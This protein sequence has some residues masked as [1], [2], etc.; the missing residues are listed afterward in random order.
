MRRLKATN[1]LLA[2]RML[3]REWHAGELRI[4]SAALVVAVGSITAVG[5]FTD[6]VEQAMVM[7]AAELLAADTLMHSSEPISESYLDSARSLGLESARTLS[8]RSVLLIA[9]AFQLTEVKAVGPGYPL[10]GKLRIADTPFELAAPETDAIPAI[11]SVWLDERL[12][13]V[14]DVVV[15]DTLELGLAKFTIEAVLVYEP[16]RGGDLFSIAPRLMMHLDDVAATDL[17]QPGSRVTHTVLFAGDSGAITAYRDQHEP[18]LNDREHFHDVKDARPEMR[19]AL[20]RAEQFLGLAALVSVM[21][22]GAAIAVSS[23][24]YASRQLDAAAIMRCLGASQAVIS[25]LYAIQVFAL[26]LVASLLGCLAGYLAQLVLVILFKDLLVGSLPSPTFMPIG[27]GLMTGI[28]TLAGFAL[29]PIL[30][31]K[32]VPPSRVLRRELG[33]IPVISWSAMLAPLSALFVLILWQAQDLQ[34]A[35]YVLAGALVSVALLALAA[36]VLVKLLRGL[37]KNVGVALRFGLSNITRRAPSSVLQVTAFGLGIMMLLLLTIV[38]SDVLDEWQRNLPADAP[39]FFLINIQPS[40][41]DALRAWMEERGLGQIALYPMVRGRLEAINEREVSSEDYDEDR[42][43][44]LARREFNLSWTSQLPA[45][46]RVVSGQWW[47][48][49]ED[50]PVFSVEEGLAETLGIALGDALTFDIAGQIVQAQVTNLRF[51]EWDSFNVNF[52]VVSPP[53]L[54]KDHPATFISSFHL[55]RGRRPLLV[56]LVREF[57]SV[58]VLDVDA[59]LTKVRQIMERAVLGVEYV[60]A[61]TLVAG[62]I[63]LIAAV[64]STMDERRFETAIIRTL[65]G[66]KCALL[67]GLL[68]E[69]V[70]LGCLAGG[71]AALFATL[72]GAVLAEQ[73]FEL[74]YQPDA[75]LMIVGVAAGGIGIG[76]AGVLRAR[77]ALQHPPIQVLR[78]I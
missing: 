20:Q 22:S 75:S 42:A 63:V 34:L 70:T 10:R 52:F 64:E 19:I 8:F 23:R 47:S 77:S 62:V 37:R 12:M 21:L 35:I 60:F 44:R 53:S 45:D 38:R 16:D 26:G 17:V 56:T 14:L 74:S 9:D 2:L 11:G 18:T 28:L 39:N 55:P 68:A 32:N 66:R 13:S 43:R 48:P 27:I 30:R 15:G 69:F 36:L 59:L 51:V 29:P 58:T 54:L 7:Q 6:R 4:L 24:R 78:S 50:T 67:A 1:F 73:I 49:L 40:E 25:R 65:G 76:I 41:V 3:L 33:Q 5:F 72:V 31:L 57:P 46:N 71:L 61:F